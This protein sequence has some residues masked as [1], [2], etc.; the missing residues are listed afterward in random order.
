MFPVSREKEDALRSRMAALGV[1]EED[2]DEQFVRAG[3]HG[4]QNVDKTSTCVVLVHRP[5]GVRVRC[6]R[7]RSQGLNRFLARRALLE[8]L[9]ALRQGIA[10]AAARERARIRRQ[11]RRRSK[12]AEEKRL[13]AKH[14][15]AE[16]KAARRPPTID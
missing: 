9:E 2:L 11:K 6:A 4:G 8:K 12:R 5:T 10:D 15:T 1:R 14:A 7:E 3:G 13:A 16:K